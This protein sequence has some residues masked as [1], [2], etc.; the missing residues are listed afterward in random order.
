M[1]EINLNESLEFDEEIYNHM[2]KSFQLVKKIEQ[3]AQSQF[4]EIMKDIKDGKISLEDVK[5]KRGLV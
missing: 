1:K 4:N 5:K 2:P 3:K